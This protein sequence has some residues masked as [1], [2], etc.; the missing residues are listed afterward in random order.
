MLNYG[1]T[2]YGRAEEFSNTR[3]AHI[4][5]YEQTSTGTELQCYEP[6]NMETQ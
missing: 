1:V 2:F 3:N 6:E 5:I 4:I